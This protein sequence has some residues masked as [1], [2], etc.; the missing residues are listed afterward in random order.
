MWTFGT[1]A[2]VFG[3]FAAWK[4]VADSRAS[5]LNETI[6][7]G[8]ALF[9]T[10]FSISFMF[11]EAMGFAFLWRGTSLSLVVFVLACGLLDLLYLFLLKAPTLS[12]RHLMDQVEGFKSFLG[13]V[14]GDLLNRMSPP[15]QTPEVFERFLPYA[16]ALNVNS[17]GSFTSAISAA[18]LAPGSG[19]G[20]GA[21]GSGGGGGGGGGGGW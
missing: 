3:V 10:L 18:S 8:K 20:G 17:S 12:G 1:S 14:D 11:G 19:S 6:V 7:I 15:Q 9:T 13:A 5:A 2:L 21:G 16:L 4:A